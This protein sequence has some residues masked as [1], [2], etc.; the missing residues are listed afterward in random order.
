MYGLSK[1]KI[2]VVYNG[3]DLSK[4]EIKNSY[5][6]GDILHIIHVGRFRAQKNH[7]LLINAFADF[8]KKY[9]D[10]DL[11]LLGDGELEEN[12]KSLVNSLSIS[13]KVRFEG[14]RDNVFP[15]LNKADIFVLPSLYEGVPMSIIEAMGTGLPIIASNVGGIPDMLKDGDDALLINSGMENLRNAFIKLTDEGLREKLGKAALKGAAGRFS[16][17]AMAQ[18]YMKIYTA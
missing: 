2:P 7:E 1:E 13:D 12:I 14:S 15:Y 17:K 9:P 16:S 6:A 18:S 4:C 3:I 5:H 10:A 11:T 8:V